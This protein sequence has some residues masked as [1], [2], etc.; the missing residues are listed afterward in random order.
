MIP[1]DNHLQQHPME[2]QQSEMDGNHHSFQAPGS[3][4]S[5]ARLPTSE[6]GSKLT[7]IKIN[8]LNLLLISCI[9]ARPQ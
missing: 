5:E 3:F 8:E 9:Q 7:V 1:T 6:E 2:Q 4:S